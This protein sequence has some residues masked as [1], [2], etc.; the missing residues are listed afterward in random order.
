MTSKAEQ[1]TITDIKNDII[2]AGDSTLADIFWQKNK[3]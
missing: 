1:F 2:S 3:N